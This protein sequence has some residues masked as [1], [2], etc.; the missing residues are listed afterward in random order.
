M[1]EPITPT[2]AVASQQAVAAGF[3]ASA[4]GYFHIEPW[5]LSVSF[6]GAVLGLASAPKGLA[7]WHDFLV[8]C[9]VAFGA[10]WIGAS[11]TP[12]VTKLAGPDFNHPEGPATFILAAVFHPGVNWLKGVLPKILSARFGVAKGE[13]Q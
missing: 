3:A 11:A 8:F 4:L 6:F 12:W 5:L 1:A 9:A 13:A 10:S 7:K 2:L